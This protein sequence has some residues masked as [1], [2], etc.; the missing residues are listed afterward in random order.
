MTYRIDFDRRTDKASCSAGFDGFG[1]DF[2][3]ASSDPY[4]D[5]CRA[6][7]DAGMPDGPATFVDQRGM[8]CMTVGSIHGAAR[9]YRPTPQ[10]AAER[11]ARKEAKGKGR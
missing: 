8:A 9:L 1:G 4:F 10:E 6:M 2:V 3:W 7:T 5:V 11:A